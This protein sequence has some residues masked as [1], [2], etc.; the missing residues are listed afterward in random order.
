M[1]VSDPTFALVVVVLATQL[2]EI[3]HAFVVAPTSAVARILR[4]HSSPT[5]LL[6]PTGNKH[7]PSSVPVVSPTAARV[8]QRDRLLASRPSE[9]SRPGLWEQIVRTFSKSANTQR[10][11]P[12]AVR[13]AKDR[14]RVQLVT[15]LRVGIPSILSGIAAYFVFP[16]AALTLAGAMHA[17]G[18]FT[19]LSQDSSQFVQN[20]LTVAGLLFSILV[21]QTCEWIAVCSVC[22]FCTL[23][24]LAPRDGTLTRK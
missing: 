16:V 18:V 7:A 24:T 23:C 17:P 12:A 3:S 20:F 9:A 2:C 6:E 14:Q 21:G 15:L 19:V 10:S 13:S 5:L 22:C 11:S 8:R 4:R 1:K